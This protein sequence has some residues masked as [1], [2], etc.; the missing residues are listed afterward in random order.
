[1][2]SCMFG[3]WTTAHGAASLCEKQESGVVDAAWFAA[4]WTAALM[5]E[6]YRWLVLMPAGFSEWLYTLE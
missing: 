6:S 4:S 2:K 3:N 1:M 5:A